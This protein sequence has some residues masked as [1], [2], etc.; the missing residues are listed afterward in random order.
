MRLRSTLQHEDAVTSL[1]AHPPPQSHLLISASADR[2][3][4]TWDARTGKLLREHTGHRG[5]VLDASLGLNG[6]VIVSAGDDGIC[7]VFTTE[8]TDGDYLVT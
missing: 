7:A 6:S 5:P 4:K 8:S 2:T 1:L 3:L